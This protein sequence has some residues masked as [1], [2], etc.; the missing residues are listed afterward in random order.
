VLSPLRQLMK[1][2]GEKFNGGAKKTVLGWKTF[3]E[4][5]ID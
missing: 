1:I 2:H 5:K 4:M 3:A